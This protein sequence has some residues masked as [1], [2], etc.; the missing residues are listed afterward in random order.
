M[1]EFAAPT[2][3]TIRIGSLKRRVVNRRRRGC[4][5]VAPDA[6][7]RRRYGVVDVLID[8]VR[9]MP[10]QRQRIRVAA[11]GRKRM[12]RQTVRVDRPLSRGPYVRCRGNVP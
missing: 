5:R 4:L 6:P 1:N 11:A 10:A 8:E 12:P 7:R 2:V 9:Q 3:E